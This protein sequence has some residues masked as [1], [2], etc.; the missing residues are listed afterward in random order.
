M[1]SF[2]TWPPNYKFGYMCAWVALVIGAVLI[3]VTVVA[4][5]NLQDAVMGGIASLVGAVLVA[6]MPRWALDGE[7]EVH[8]RR[9]ARDARREGSSLKGV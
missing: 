2:S 1:R 5:N 7:E 4:G 3:V 8:R 6:C 9:R